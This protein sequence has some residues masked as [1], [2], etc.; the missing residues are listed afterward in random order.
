[1]TLHNKFAATY[2]KKLI[3]LAKEKIPNFL[4]SIFYVILVFAPWSGFD[5]S[6][7]GILCINFDNKT[8]DIFQFKFNDSF[9][10]ILISHEWS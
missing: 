9:Y 5:L 6:Y 3:T 4:E 1:M 7:N 8:L 10:K 2:Y